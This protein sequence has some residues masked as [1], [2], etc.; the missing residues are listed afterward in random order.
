METTLLF[1]CQDGTTPAHTTFQNP[2][3]AY[4]AGTDHPV[5]LVQVIDRTRHYL[6]PEFER[7]FTLAEFRQWVESQEAP[8]AEPI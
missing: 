5:T 6:H 1:R 2:K 7:L 3:E 4:L 8:V